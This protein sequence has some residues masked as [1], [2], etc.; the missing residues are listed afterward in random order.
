MQV[1]ENLIE[2]DVYFSDTKKNKYFVKVSFLSADMY[3]NSFLVQ[4]SQ[5]PDS[6]WWVQPPKHFQGGRWV[7][8]VDFSKKSE[9]WKVIQRKAIEAVE[10]DKHSF[11]KRMSADIVLK[12]IDNG[13]IDLSEIPF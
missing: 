1:D 10:Q 5:F 7:A 2:A 9:L 13:P 4:P 8:T 6:P 11:S 3:I 12:D